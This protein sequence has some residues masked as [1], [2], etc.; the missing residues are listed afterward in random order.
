[1]K[2]NAAT[3]NNA[4]PLPRKFLEIYDKYYPGKR[5]YTMLDQVLS[6][7]LR[8]FH[9]FHKP[10][11]NCKCDESGYIIW[12]NNKFT[13]KGNLRR[14][15]QM[16][17]EFGFGLEKYSSPEKCFNFWYQN[18]ILYRGRY[19]NDL[20]EL[21]KLTLMKDLDSLNDDDCIKLI[22]IRR[23]PNRNWDDTELNQLVRNLKNL[24]L[25]KN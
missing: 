16:Y 7:N 21:S 10:M 2:K 22:F 8:Y 3:V 9:P 4:K 20:N 5:N 15:M 11:K 17:P 19:L 23:Q 14:L 13:F 6:Q 24:N 18:D 25:C 12:E 1:M